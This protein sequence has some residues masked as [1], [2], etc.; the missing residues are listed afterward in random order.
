MFG[1]TR[2]TISTARKSYLKYEDPANMD[3]KTS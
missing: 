3:F 1:S 2:E